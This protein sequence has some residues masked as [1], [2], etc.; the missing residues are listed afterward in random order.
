MT[1]LYLGTVENHRNT[2][3]TETLIFVECRESH[4]FAQNAFLPK[5]RSFT[6]LQEYFVFNRHKLK[7]IV[8]I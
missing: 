4:D 1:M 2:E 3:I 7:F 8:W 5:F 6:F